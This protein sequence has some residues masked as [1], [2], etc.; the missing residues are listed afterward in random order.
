MF[1]LVRFWFVEINSK[2]KHNF[3]STTQ[4][5]DCLTEFNERILILLRYEN[6]KKNVVRQTVMQMKLIS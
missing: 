2:V 1:V 5:P 3:N 6:D 4:R